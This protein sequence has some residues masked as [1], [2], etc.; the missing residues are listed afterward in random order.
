L[1]VG[2]AF[3]IRADGTPVAERPLGTLA[4]HGPTVYF[5]YDPA[6]LAESLPVSP[7]HTPARAGLFNHAHRDF[8]RLPGL[9]ADSAP[10]GWGRTVQDRAFAAIGVD[11]ARIT[12]LDRLAAVGCAAMGALTFRPVE[13]L[14]ADASNAGAGWP[15]DLE[16]V[17]SQAVRVF[18]G[19]AEELLPALRLGGGSPGGARP[20]V[21]AG[22]AERPNGNIDIFTGVTRD[23]L[24]GRATALPPAYTPWLIKF[25]AGADARLFGRDVGA[26][27][28][29]YAEMARRAG[30]DVPSTRLLQAADGERHFAIERFDRFGP[31]GIERRHMHTASGLLHA[32]FREPSLDYEMLM[33]LAQGL[34]HAVPASLEVLRRAAFNVFTHNRDDHARNFAFLMDDAGQW[35]FS[36]A[37][38]L[39]Y[40]EGLNGHHTTSVA[41]ESLSPGRRQ[42]EQLADRR[43]LPMGAVRAAIDEVIDQVGQW[44]TVAA[45]L[46]IA[47]PV[48]DRLEQVFTRVRR[49]SEGRVASA[50][51]ESRRR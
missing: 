32:S 23:L 35:S 30:L 33:K 47:S 26:V 5:E 2:L 1:H 49:T 46:E 48:I 16:R 9:I 20:K 36:P 18:D 25:G 6:F 3:G 10:D 24:I 31:G 34:T 40:G 38:D 50:P 29:A 22:L 15:L 4:E 8:D 14:E 12:I 13:M 11:R 37:Y 41:D 44:R 7:L 27:E 19:S 17:A 28:A 51:R 45:S 43:D 42:L 39:M 21:L